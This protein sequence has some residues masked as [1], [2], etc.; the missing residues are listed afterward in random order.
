[1]ERV[2]WWRIGVIL[3]V[4]LL[5]VV[6]IAPTLPSFYETMFGYLERS[7]Q[8]PEGLAAPVILD[9]GLEFQFGAAADGSADDLK[10]AYRSAVT[11]LRTRGKSIG[12]EDV[13][14][15]AA[16]APIEDATRVS[17][18]ILMAYTDPRGRAAQA[19][20]DELHLYG[21]IPTSLGW[22]FPQQR[23]QLGLDLKGGVYLVLELD[24]EEAQ[25]QLLAEL[26]TNIKAD[27]RERY[28]VNCREVLPPDGT[29]LTAVIKPNS[30]W[31]TP[32][33]TRKPDTEAYF[34]GVENLTI[35]PVNSGNAGADGLVRYRLTLDPTQL[36]QQEDQ[37]LTQVLEVLRNRIDAF[38]VSEPDI[39]R[40]PSRP[41]II[42]QLPGAE[43]SSTAVNVVRTMGRLE[44]RMVQMKDGQR[45][46]GANDPPGLEGLP[47]DAELLFDEDGV[48]FVVDRAAVVTGGE[49]NRA[50]TSTYLADIVVTLRFNANGRRAFGQ[51]TSEHTNE[52]MAIVLD[53]RVISAPNIEQPILTGN[54]IIRGGFT[55]EDASDLA[56]VLRAGAFPVGVK[57]AEER[58]VGPSL[59]REAI[60]RGARAAG[61]GLAI[62]L[63]FLLIYYS[64]CG[65]FSAFALLVNGVI[66]LAALALLGATLTL[67]GLAGLVLTIGMAVDA[68][69]LINERIKEELRTGK[70]VASAITA[71]YGR[72]FWTIFDANLT[73]FLTALVLYM[74]GTGAIKGFGVTLMI[75]I[76]ASMFT[77]LF[78][79]RTFY[80]I[81]ESRGRTRL[82]IY[83]IFSGP[84]S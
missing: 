9:E 61:I 32:G 42:V 3:F 82:P 1:M 73:T 30:D 35:E 11:T 22:L 69:V 44:F 80:R 31:G 48:W 43:D 18:T 63:V 67:P 71:G 20:I 46:Y 36:Q 19:V 83:P 15:N 52:L 49:I 10:R 68:N 37:A 81:F 26:Q 50:G 41:R 28:S 51:A 72:V 33:D 12:L 74:F 53:D 75:G 27:L 60:V 84:Q 45:W 13:T 24:M 40:D 2:R 16:A 55:Q 34:A 23:I 76:V 17:D 25:G 14:L 58:T 29:T 62:V 56:R 66:I 47:S 70:T 4:L 59:G 54:A 65:F 77:A 38:G 39:R 64:T 78:V 6:N 21:K 7:L 57:I 79:A 8:E 5:S